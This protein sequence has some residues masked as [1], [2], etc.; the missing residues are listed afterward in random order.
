ML[1]LSRFR[2]PYAKDPLIELSDGTSADEVS[3]GRIMQRYAARNRKSPAVPAAVWRCL[4]LSYFVPVA[5]RGPWRLAGRLV[6]SVK[7]N[8]VYITVTMLF[9]SSYENVQRRASFV[10]TDHAL[11]N[12]FNASLIIR[13]P[14]QPIR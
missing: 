9:K 2:Q 4:A 6:D 12:Y 3:I 10:P 13:V 5:T 1:R 11:P 7:H 14:L 8:L